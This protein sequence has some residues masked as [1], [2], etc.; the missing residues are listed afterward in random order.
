MNVGQ[1]KKY[2]A[3]LPDDTVILKDGAESG[4]F[5]KAWAEKLYG[6]QTSRFVF[7]EVYDGDEVP[8]DSRAVQI[9][10]IR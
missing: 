3:E 6:I 5:V 10:V 7:E 8:E 2:I 9:L 1:L 4:L